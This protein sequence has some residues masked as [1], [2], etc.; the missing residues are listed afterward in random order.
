MVAEMI[1][2]DD[3]TP[4]LYYGLCETSVRSRIYHVETM[5]HDSH[6]LYVGIEGSLMRSCINAES[7]TADHYKVGEIWR[8]IDL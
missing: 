1:F 6:S 7:Q 8:K 3:C 4:G 5:R 2:R